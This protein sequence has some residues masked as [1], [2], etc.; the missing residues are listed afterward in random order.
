MTVVVFSL[1]QN[2]GTLV[3]RNVTAERWT[4]LP[5]M[6]GMG[7]LGDFEKDLISCTQP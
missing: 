2:K 7:G 3:T 4:I 5:L 6:E 1:G